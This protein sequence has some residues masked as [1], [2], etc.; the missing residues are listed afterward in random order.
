V[1][2]NRLLR[3]LEITKKQLTDCKG[4][5]KSFELDKSNLEVELKTSQEASIML[6]SHINRLFAI[7]VLEEV[8]KL[9]CVGHWFD[10]WVR[11]STERDK[12]WFHV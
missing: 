10:I 8:G 6:A 12:V 9:T 2:Q 5:L 3:E 11:H 1:E 7:L 4:Q